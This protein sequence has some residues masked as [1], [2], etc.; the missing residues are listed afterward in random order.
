VD[1]YTK[2]A[3]VV[4]GYWWLPV[5]GAVIGLGQLLGSDVPLRVRVVLARMIV[6]AGV[7]MSSSALLLLI[8]DVSH[9]AVAGVGAA[10]GSLGTSTLEKIA[11]RVIEKYLGDR[12]NEAD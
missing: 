2:A 5:M 8:P 3:E 4:M 10:M 12:K 1:K 6:T 7:A 11:D 9:L